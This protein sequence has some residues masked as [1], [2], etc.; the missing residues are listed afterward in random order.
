MLSHVHPVAVLPMVLIS[1]YVWYCAVSSVGVS[2][3]RSVR[4]VH[5][6]VGATY[7]LPAVGAARL[8]GELR[9]C[10]RTRAFK[11]EGM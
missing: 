2:A 4:R 11:D 6:H 5:G 10:S 8:A 9:T 3:C 1:K 7:T